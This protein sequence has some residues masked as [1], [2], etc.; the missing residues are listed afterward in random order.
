MAGASS[1]HHARKHDV[2]L[3]FV[4]RATR[5]S[6][7]VLGNAV[8]DGAHLPIVER[9]ELID[10]AALRGEAQPSHLFFRMSFDTRLVLRLYRYS[11][12]EIMTLIE[13]QMASDD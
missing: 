3:P 5:I 7:D 13:A 8:A 2:Y 11:R 4:Q 1:L 10:S 12:K 9:C 6:E